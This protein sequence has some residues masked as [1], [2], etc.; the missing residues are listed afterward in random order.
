MAGLG[1]IVEVKETL[2]AEGALFAI[3]AESSARA[4]TIVRNHFRAAQLI[5]KIKKPLSKD[6][7]SKFG[8]KQGEVRRMWNDVPGRQFERLPI[9][10]DHVAPPP[11][12]AMDT[13]ARL[14][15]VKGARARPAPDRAR[16]RRVETK[17]ETQRR[18][19][20]IATKKR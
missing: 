17:R 13:L 19:R 11:E 3:L 7:I 20:N 9:A 5:V 8:L 16:I 4:T 1:W 15:S 18:R 6:E 14:E 12:K 2:G 10:V